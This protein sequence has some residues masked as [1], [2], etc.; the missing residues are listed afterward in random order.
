MNCPLLVLG[1]VARIAILIRALSLA[2][3][4][5]RYALAFIPSLIWLPLAS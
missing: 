1:F 2:V 3:C 4:G 5:G